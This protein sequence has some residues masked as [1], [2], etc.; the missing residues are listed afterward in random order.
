[1]KIT[2]SLILFIVKYY[3]RFYIVLKSRSLR[4]KIIFQL[5]RN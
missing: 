4:V 2:N 5:Y 1:M 3:I